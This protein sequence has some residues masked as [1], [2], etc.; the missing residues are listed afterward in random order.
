VNPND[1][2]L[3]ALLVAACITDVR[4]QKIRNIHTFPAIVAGLVASPFFLPAWWTGL[5]GFIVAFALAV[6]G[7]RFGGAIRAGDV[8]LLLAV[9]ALTGP[10]VG[11]RAVLWS[12]ALAFPFGLAVL[13]AR[14]RLGRL[15]RFWVKGERSDPTLVAYG[16]VIAVATLLA[17]FWDWP[18]LG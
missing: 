9:G 12:Y 17:R 3:G 13:L 16:P 10:E 18:D 11:A 14:G 1:V 4:E 7:W 8:K 2:V 6:P 5:A 15:W